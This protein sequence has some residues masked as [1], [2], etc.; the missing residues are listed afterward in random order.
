MAGSNGSAGCV[1]EKNEMVSF[2]EEDDER[3]AGGLCPFAARG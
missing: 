1:W 2:G 3:V